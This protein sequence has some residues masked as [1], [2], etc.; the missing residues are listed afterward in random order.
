MAKGKGTPIMAAKRRKIPVFRND[1]EEREFWLTHRVEKF[2]DEMT[3]LEVEIRP[4]R[5]EQ[6]AIRMSKEHLQTLRA[7]AASKGV[8]HTTLVRT[9]LEQWLERQRHKTAG[10]SRGSQSSPT[11]VH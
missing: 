2:A 4:P 11:S 8:G 3:E 6:I 9:I 5:T 1:R 10:P 7:L